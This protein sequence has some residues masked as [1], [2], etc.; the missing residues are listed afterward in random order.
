MTPGERFLAGSIM[1]GNSVALYGAFRSIGVKADNFKPWEPAI[2]TGGPMWEIM[3]ETLEAFGGGPEGKQSRAALLG[4]SRKNG[5]LSFDP[6]NSTLFKWTVPGAFE[7]R[8]MRD[9]VKLTNEGDSWGAFLTSMGAPYSSDW[10][11][12]Q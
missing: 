8:K 7:I 12:L 2:F 1:V 3:Q 4:L 6:L 11:V 9:A 10:E 5:K